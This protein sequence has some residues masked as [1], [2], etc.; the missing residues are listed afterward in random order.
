VQ[1]VV[2]YPLPEFAV[3][4]FLAVDITQAEIPVRPLSVQELA[5]RALPKREVRK[6]LLVFLFQ[7][8]CTF[9][10]VSWNHGCT[11]SYRKVL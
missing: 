1:L 9:I 11:G 5:P 8:F 3:S 2:F 6:Q 10:G 4:Q 7:T